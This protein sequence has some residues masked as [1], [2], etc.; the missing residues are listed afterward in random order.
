MENHAVL[1]FSE[2]AG[3]LFA[4]FIWSN[5]FALRVTRDTARRSANCTVEQI[6][7]DG[8]RFYSVGLEGAGGGRLLRGGTY[9]RNIAGT[10]IH[11]LRVHQGITRKAQFY[12][13]DKL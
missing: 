2:I 7:S 6:H 12:K 13:A 1:M 3:D 10:T 9:M 11:R 5:E 4:W 8:K